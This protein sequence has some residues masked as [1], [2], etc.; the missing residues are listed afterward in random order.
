MTRGVWKGNQS[1]YGALSMWIVREVF[2][3]PC[4]VATAEAPGPT[5]SAMA[6]SL[7]RE[8]RVRR[9]FLVPDACLLLVHA[10]CGLPIR[11]LRPHYAWSTVSS[12]LSCHGPR[13]VFCHFCQVLLPFPPERLIRHLF[14]SHLR[15][16]MPDL[17]SAQLLCMVER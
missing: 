17:Q 7:L 6:G 4:D 11:F 10:A 12:A 15:G 2:W 1:R 16:C 3:N 5:A 9:V 8:S 13:S 14:C